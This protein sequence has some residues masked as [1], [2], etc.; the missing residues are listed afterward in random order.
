MTDERERKERTPDPRGEGRHKVG[1][2]VGAYAGLGFQFAAAII[3]FLFA[4][5]WLDRRLGT[6]WFA[7]I[8]MFVGAAAGFYSMYRRLMADQRREDEARRAARKQ[9]D[10]K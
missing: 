9:T 4:G 2:S 5:Q 6:E 10:R 8:G 3:L 1:T 7:I